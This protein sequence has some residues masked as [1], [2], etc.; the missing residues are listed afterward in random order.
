MTVE[1]VSPAQATAECH[2]GEEIEVEMLEYERL[3]SKRL[4]QRIGCT[5][6]PP[7]VRYLP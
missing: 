1:R 6:R 2:G 3:V 7:I 5:S 4:R